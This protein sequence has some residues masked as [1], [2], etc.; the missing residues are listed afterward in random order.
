MEDKSMSVSRL[1][2]ITRIGVE[3][4][5]DLADSLRDPEIL[6]LE[7]LDTDLRPP[8]SALDYTKQ[9]V[10]DD[11][12]NSYLPF[13]GLD[14][15][16]RTAAALVGRQS[17]QHYDWKTECIV[18]AGGLSGILNVLLAVLEPGDEV[19]MTDPIYSGLINRVRLAGGVP[20][21]VPL[22]PSPQGWHLDAEVLAA[23]DPRP[24]K[25]ALLMSPSMPTGAVFTA[26]EWRLLAAFCERADCWLIN[27]A[28]MERI[29]YDGRPV[30]HPAAL[31]GMREKTITIG[32]AS[33]EYRMIGWRVGWVV[34]PATIVAD[35]ARVS[36]TNVVCQTGIAMGAVATA[37][38]APDDGIRACVAEWQRRRD[39]LLAELKEFS[40]IPPHGG[41]SLLLNVSPMGLDG[42]TA[43]KRLLQAGK[44]AATPMT[45]WGGAASSK[46]VRLVFA[47]EPVERLCGIGE[48]IGR[49]LA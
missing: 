12:A 11:D 21:F 15:L 40:V 31:P 43:S 49:A 38:N 42:P 16:R 24:V 41:W 1:T 13:F 14:V 37:I 26:D 32:S 35:A 2:H 4:M 46:Y 22:I 23:I 28:A 10:D 48:R 45:H 19:L 8:H 44:I 17:G 33:K 30:I 6:R 36:I 39:V 7:N 29:L 25:A 20:R 18:S 27:D 34:G 5:G 9:A 47:N 3:Q